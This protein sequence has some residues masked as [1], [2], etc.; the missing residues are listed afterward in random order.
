MQGT[1]E[2]Q[3]KPAM[4]FA[5]RLWNLR[6]EYVTGKNF[7]QFDTLIA[8][9]IKVIAELFKKLKNIAISVMFSAM[10]L[11]VWMSEPSFIETE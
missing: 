11:G 3:L 5:I 8:P 9:P 4:D 10:T 6:D 1:F 7:I 2:D